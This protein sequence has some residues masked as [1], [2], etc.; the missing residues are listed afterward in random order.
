MLILGS[1]PNLKN[2]KSLQWN[3][4]I[5][6]ALTNQLTLD[7]AYVGTHGYDEI[8]SV[9]L[10]EP[11]SAPGGIWHRSV[12]A[13]AATCHRTTAT[14]MIGPAAPT[15]KTNCARGYCR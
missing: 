2:P 7:V 1:D 10:N 14:A 11:Q 5:Q 4:D 6:R 12:G 15:Y 13:V 3:V 9:D 8:D